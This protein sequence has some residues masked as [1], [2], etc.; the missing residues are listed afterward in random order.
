MAPEQRIGD[1]VGAR[2]DLYALGLMLI[3]MLTGRCPF[4]GKPLDILRE[5][6]LAEGPPDLS[7]I[8]HVG[9][10]ELIQKLVVRRPEGRFQSATDLVAAIDAQL[11]SPSPSIPTA[12][13]SAAIARPSSDEARTVPV[14]KRPSWMLPAAIAGASLLVG[15]LLMVL[16][17]TSSK[18]DGTSPA[19]SASIS[20]TPPIASEPPPPASV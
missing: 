4:E 16:F 5:R 10:R 13:P 20:A 14:S 18:A 12:P 15:V 11:T 17:M 1:T 7:A 8:G 19:A 6:I 2:A 9:A 3:Q